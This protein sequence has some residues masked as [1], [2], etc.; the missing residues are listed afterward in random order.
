MSW[1]PC[2]GS[3]WRASGYVIQDD[4]IWA[5]PEATIDPYDLWQPFYEQWAAEHSTGD[6]SGE[7][8]RTGVESGDHAT[9][10]PAAERPRTSHS[11]RPSRSR[12]APSA[13]MA[14]L[15]L[16]LFDEK[17]ILGWVQANGLLGVL[18]ERV[19]SVAL[20]P[21]PFN[22]HAWVNTVTAG[23]GFQ[24]SHDE[25]V[26]TRWSR[27]GGTWHAAI[28]PVSIGYHESIDEDDERQF[29]RPLPYSTTESHVVI[30]DLATGLIDVEPLA[31]SWRTFFREHTGPTYELFP[32]YQSLSLDADRTV[33]FW[34]QYGE[35]LFEF[36]RAVTALRVAV[37]KVSALDDDFS[38]FDDW[39]A[40]LLPFLNSTGAALSEGRFGSVLVQC[41]PVSLIS[42]YAVMLFER[43]RARFLPGR[44]LNDRCRK[45]FWRARANARH[46]NSSCQ[47]ADRDQR[48]EMR[49]HQK[50]HPPVY[51]DDDDVFF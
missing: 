29:L 16:N 39:F 40:P 6:T 50:K 24:F 37:A 20:P 14:L 46:C 25:P 22:I 28:R 26:Q 9:T 49:R 4:T 34:K 3:W 36:R 48:K 21:V 7:T 35:P 38:H 8:S 44:C 5:A 18:P 19:L 27:S 42:A 10:A 30:R 51:R 13:L 12:P 32:P 23:G 45:F 33:R 2:L 31:G 43:G 11:P 47:Q 17:A 41:L 1:T 15:N